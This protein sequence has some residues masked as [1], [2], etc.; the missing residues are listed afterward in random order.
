MAI[1]QGATNA[2]LSVFSAGSGGPTPAKV[3]LLAGPGVRHAGAEAA[4]LAAAERFDIPIATTLGGKG[5]VPEDHPLALGVF[6]Y[7]GS[8][9]ASEAILDPDVAVLIVVGS[10]LSQRDTLNW[11]PGMLSTAELI[12]VE[13]DPSLIGRTWPSSSP[14]TASPKAFLEQLAA[15]DGTVADG[16][17]NGRA[18][19]RAFLAD[20]RGR[21]P[22][23]YEADDT[24]SDAE[25]MHPARFVTQARAAC[26]RDTVLSVDSG[27]H[28]AWCSQYW[29]SYGGGDYVSLAN[30]APMGVRSLWASAPR[31]R[32][33]NVRWS[34]PRATAAC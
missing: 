29:P 4:L 11:D 25:P 33:P 23:A 24:A 10:A 20:V 28:R 34:S 7:G 30:L 9:W 26:P 6:G 15:V 14:V 19:R 17:D 3:V 12:H 18:T 1:D 2:A 32:A 27:A 21:G 8:R 16:L 22:R 5:T 31:W 13:A